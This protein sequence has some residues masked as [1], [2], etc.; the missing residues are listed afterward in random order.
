[1]GQI[2]A[3]KQLSQRSLPKQQED[4]AAIKALFTQLNKFSEKLCIN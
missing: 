3:R 2:K 1:M 4:C